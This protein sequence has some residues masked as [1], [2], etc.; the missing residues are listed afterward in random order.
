MAATRS[1]ISDFPRVSDLQA[2]LERAV[3][4]PAGMAVLHSLGIADDGCMDD[5]LVVAPGLQVEGA[6]ASV[7]LGDS[8][9]AGVLAML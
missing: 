7:G 9:T 1:R 8:F 6:T 3:V 4:N 5:T 2:T